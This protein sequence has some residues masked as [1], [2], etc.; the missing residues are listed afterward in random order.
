MAIA[1]A[2]NRPASVVDLS[3]ANVPNLPAQ[4]IA[5][6]DLIAISVYDSPE[7][8]RTL[9][10]G[11]DG[12]IRF[13]MLKKPIHA[14]RMLP[15]QL[16]AAIAEALKA[17]EILVDPMVTVT[18]VAYDSRPVNVLGAVRKPI[19]FQ[20]S[21][22]VTLIDAL[23]RAEGLTPDAG[24][25][26]LLSRSLSGENQ[27]SAAL[28]QRIPVRS[29]IDGADHPELNVRLFGG[30]EIRVPDARKIYVAGSVKK[31]GAF[32]VHDGSENTVMKLMAMVEGVVPY[33]SKEAFVYRANGE[34][35][36]RSEI[37]IPLAKI[38]ERKSPDVP[39]MPDDILYVPDSKG[40]RAGLTA[41]EKV[42]LYGSGA[43]SAMIYAGVR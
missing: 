32:P 6:N 28:V 43:A 27:T 31:P 3:V 39:L 26:I 30:E 29:L 20:V 14:E 19:T 8:T 5:P 12:A 11:A 33:A 40:K 24:P 22:K 25:E 2:Q 35:R 9:R 36:P 37:L 10:V 21:G 7:L 18:V 1:A 42:L 23:A 15:A 13:P 34:G 38:L 4:E 41:L 17:E 16:E